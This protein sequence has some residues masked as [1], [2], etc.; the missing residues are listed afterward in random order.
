MAIIVD[1]HEL[2]T[3][4]MAL[5]PR[6]AT[7][8][9][10]AAKSAGVFLVEKNWMEGERLDFRRRRPLRAAIS[11]VVD[12]RITD[13]KAD[14]SAASDDTFAADQVPRRLDLCE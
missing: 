9:I 11:R 2:H 8:R 3:A 13:S 5:A 4:G 7:E 1:E 10:S 14:P 6:E 12:C